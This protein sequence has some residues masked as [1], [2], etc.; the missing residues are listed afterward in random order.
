MKISKLLIAL[1]L[2]ASCTDQKD[3]KPND[4]TGQ[5]KVVYIDGCEYLTSNDQ[6]N[7]QLAHKGNC[8]QC[9]INH[10][11]VWFDVYHEQKQYDARNSK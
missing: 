9:Q 6:Y 1:A 7:D 5:F 2:F 3:Q 4:L 10:R 8:K 11:Q